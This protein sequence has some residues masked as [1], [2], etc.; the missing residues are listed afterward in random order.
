MFIFLF[1]FIY[2]HKSKRGL[3]N[4]LEHDCSYSLTWRVESCKCQIRLNN[5]YQKSKNSSI[6]LTDQFI[7]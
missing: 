4:Y 2:M 5:D 6:S 3:V 7:G 1:L